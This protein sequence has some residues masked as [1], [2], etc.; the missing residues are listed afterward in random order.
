M[1]VEKAPFSTLNGAGDEFA[2]IA[3]GGQPTERFEFRSG[4]A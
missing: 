3:V 4:T 1:V 2:A